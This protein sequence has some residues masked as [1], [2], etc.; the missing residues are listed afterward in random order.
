[1]GEKRAGLLSCRAQGREAIDR[2]E[3]GEEGR[4]KPVLLVYLFYSPIILIVLR[5]EN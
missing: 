3:R 2:C 4:T 5:K 1:M